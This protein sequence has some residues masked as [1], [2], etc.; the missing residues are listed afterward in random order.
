MANTVL[1]TKLG[2]ELNLER[3]DLG[4]PGMPGL[5]ERLYERDRMLGSMRVPVSERGMQCA[6]VCLKAG[7]VAWM[8]LREQ[9][10]RRQAVHERA[11]DE[12][13]HTAPV[14][15]EHK[16]YQERIIRTAEGAGFRA[17]R[18]VR[19]P[20]GP[21]RWIQTD[22]LVEGDNG[23]RIGWE[24]QLST[25]AA[26]GPRSVRARAGR[27]SSHGIT[28]AWHTDRE[29]YASRNDTQWTRSNRLPARVIA[30]S[31]GL[32]VVSGFR[33]LEFWRC[34]V[35]ADLPCPDNIGYWGRCGEIHAVPK[36]RDVM[37]DDLVRR[38]A[39]GLIVPL[40]YRSGSRTQRFW[41][42]ADER[43]RYYEV[44]GAPELDPKGEEQRAG[45]GSGNGP[46]CRPRITISSSRHVLDWRDQSHWAAQPKPCRYC[47]KPTN[48]VDDHGIHMHKVCH[49]SALE[50]AAA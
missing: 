31:G 20:L 45:R 16:A 36:P 44:A 25:A 27:A 33:V 24:V 39:A 30:K 42:P 29:D 23:L 12:A 41:V 37:F 6:G 32:R 38:T 14:S 5:W 46:T 19:T 10:G 50:A 34:D 15:D 17:G 26:K 35:T 40:E 47:R 7:V 49:E 2:I 48:L 3:E 1:H 11:E 18:E 9:G 4:H 21:R 22:T 28:P 13:R 43:E 8:Y